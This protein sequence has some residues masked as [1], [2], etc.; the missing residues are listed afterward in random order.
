MN[1]SNMKI[2]MLPLLWNIMNEELFIGSLIFSKWMEKF[3]QQE[4]DMGNIGVEEAKIYH[5]MTGQVHRQ[6]F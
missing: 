2:F 6:I 4:N 3:I 5:K 1:N